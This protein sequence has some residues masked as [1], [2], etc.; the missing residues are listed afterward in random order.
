V[1]RI[2]P[3]GEPAR[4]E[5]ATADDAAASSPREPDSRTDR[6]PVSQ[7]KV[8]L[9]REAPT[10]DPPPS[11]ARAKAPGAPQKRRDS[12]PPL[13]VFS[14]S[15]STNEMNYAAQK[16]ARAVIGSNNIDSCNRT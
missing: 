15:K 11:S 8:R 14:C 3:T 1:D 7:S 2:P 4:Q 5:E 12:E 9:A 16:F 6:T 10:Q 13:R